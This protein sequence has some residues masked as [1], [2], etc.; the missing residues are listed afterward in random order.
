[1]R[2]DILDVVFQIKGVGEREVDAGDCED[3]IEWID[4]QGQ[5]TR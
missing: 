3:E 4:V 2:C 1:M 5:I